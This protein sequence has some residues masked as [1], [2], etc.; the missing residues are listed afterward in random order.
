VHAGSAVVVVEVVVVD[1][2]DDVVVV[3][4]VDVV[5]L[6]VVVDV[7][8]V[9]VVVQSKQLL[10][11]NVIVPGLVPK[12]KT[13]PVLAQIS[14]VSPLNNSITTFISEPQIPELKLE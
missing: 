7:E 3:L 14:V 9:V 10:D 8:E 11:I 13:D 2:V 6:L 4:D 12:V 5:L 1:D